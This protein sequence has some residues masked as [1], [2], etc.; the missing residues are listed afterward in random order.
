[1]EIRRSVK[2]IIIAGVLVIWAV[3]FLLRPYVQMNEALN[4]TAGIAPNLLGSFLVP[5]VAYWLYTHPGFFN[6]QLLR[7]YFFSDNRI[8]CLTGFGLALVNEYMQLIPIFGRTFDYYDLLSSAIGSIV[9]FYSFT[10][11]QRST[12]TA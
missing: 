6:G 4:F 12:S 1:M 8:V 11:M 10:Y 2:R 9:S 3:K 7:F 5:Y